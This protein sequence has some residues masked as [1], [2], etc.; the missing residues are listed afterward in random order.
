MK[1]VALITGCSTGVGLHTAAQLFKAGWIVYASMR[2]TS[3]RG[4][5]DE[6]CKGAG[7]ELHVIPLDV[8]KQDSIDAAVQL[9]FKSQAR[10]DTL[11]NNAGFGFV[12]SLEQASDQE[13]SR[14][15][16]GN[17]H[18]AARCIRAVLPMMRQAK[19]GHILAVS[20]VG[21][22][23]GQPMNEIYC[24]AKFALE[25]LFE[26]M[27]TYAEPFFGIKMTLIEPAG[28]KSEFV[29][30]VK[31]DLEATGGVYADA[32]Q[33]ILKAYFETAAKRGSFEK[34]AQTPEDVAQ[35]IVKEV[36]APSGK[37]RIQT[38]RVAQEFSH[39]KLAL[40]TDGVKLQSR[41]RRDLLG[42]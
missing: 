40:D 4:A 15:M 37:L 34:N 3:K 39:E 33:P 29:N 22:L 10:L 31:N 14:V 23:V 11:I 18:G 19:S 5:L 38:S 20:S 8:H 16:D 42:L 17:F 41:I 26:S 9:I 7:G 24:A 28:I 32:Y 1:K 36:L 21:G 2:D 27:A 35:I 6:L 13:F 30:R 25:G 12:R